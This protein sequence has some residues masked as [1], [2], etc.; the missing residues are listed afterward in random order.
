MSGGSPGMEGSCASSRFQARHRLQ[1]TSRIG[2]P[3]HRE[4]RIHRPALHDP[5]A[6]ED[7]HLVATA[8]DDAHVVGDEDDRGARIRA[9]AGE[10]AHDLRLHSDVERGGRLVGD[11]QAGPAQQGHR[12]QHPLAHASRELVRV[13]VDA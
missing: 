4:Q 2:V 3:G 6:V 1:Q 9:H 7:E 10:Q 12:D 13:H 5:A 8:R 11:Q